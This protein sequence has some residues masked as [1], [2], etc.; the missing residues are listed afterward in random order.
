MLIAG[1]KRSAYDVYVQRLLKTIPHTK[2]LLSDV[3]APSLRADESAFNTIHKP[4]NQS[5]KQ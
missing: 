3:S 4:S 1:F 2:T 5:T